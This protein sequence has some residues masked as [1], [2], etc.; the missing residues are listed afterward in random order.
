MPE[1]RQ[2]QTVQWA[3]QNP[4]ALFS[5]ATQ[6]AEA[7][8]GSLQQQQ[9]QQ[10]EQQQQQQEQ[11]QEQQQQPQ[12]QQQQKQQHQQQQEQQQELGG[13]ALGGLP[14]VI[15]TDD[16]YVLLPLACP[17]LLPLAKELLQ[18]ELPSCLRLKRMDHVTLAAA[19]QDPRQ[20]ET[21]AEFY[22]QRVSSKN[23]GSSVSSFLFCCC[24]CGLFFGPCTSSPSC[25]LTPIFV[26]CCCICCCSLQLQSV[27]A[28]LSGDPWDLVL[29]QLL[30]RSAGFV[31]EGIHA[32]QE[33]QRFSG[34]SAGRVCYPYTLH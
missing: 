11:Q 18:Q 28:Q 21:I 24:C 6:A 26:I 32:F 9:Q 7:L 31:S 16:G 20:R 4:A 29:Y 12:E 17:S 3:L 10:Q 5:I 14:H 19:R 13:V 27:A 25:P 34:L 15:S 8:R 2:Q 33:V 23:T 30:H 1:T 22:N